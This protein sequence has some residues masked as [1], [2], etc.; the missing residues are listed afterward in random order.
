MIR[1]QYQAGRRRQLPGRS[2]RTLLEP[3][4]GVGDL[5]VTVARIASG[6]MQ[7]HR[8]GPG[9]E[10]MFVPR[11]RGRLW[12]EGLPVELSPGTAA[13][14]REGMLHNAEN[15]ATGALIVIGCFS[16]SAVPGSY[17]EEAPRF[18]PTGR[19]TSS[20][21]LAV[22]I[23]WRSGGAA[24]AGDRTGWSA[25]VPRDVASR[26]VAASLVQVTPFTTFALPTSPFS[27]AWVVVRGTGSVLEPHPI[28]GPLRAFDLVAFG[29][30]RRLRLAAGSAGLRLIEFETTLTSPPGRR[31]S[32]G[33]A[34]ASRSSRS[35]TPPR[36]S[37]R[38]ERRA[39]PTSD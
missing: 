34:P 12:I 4:D 6:R 17:A 5:T 13:F 35:D 7:A 26:Y 8:H 21:E 19:L 37:P 20:A 32:D 1:R 31:L 36:G 24:H 27:R 38:S 30:G 11:G 15:T 9:G 3:R 2:V 22:R 39:P 18:S 25:V 23:P 29:P 10:V 14:V 33:S 28:S 16:P